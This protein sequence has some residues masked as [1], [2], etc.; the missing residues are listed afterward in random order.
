[1]AEYFWTSLEI[2]PSDR[3]RRRIS[4]PWSSGSWRVNATEAAQ[5]V[6]CTASQVA[7]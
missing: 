4:E 3:P 7:F 6:G 2:A 5:Q 1:M